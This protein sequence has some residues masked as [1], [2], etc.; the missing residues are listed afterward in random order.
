LGDEVIVWDDPRLSSFNLRQC[1]D[2]DDD[3]EL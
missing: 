1:D 2:V 3:D